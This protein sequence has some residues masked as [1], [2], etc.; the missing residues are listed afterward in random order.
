MFNQFGQEIVADQN[1]YGTYNNTLR[2]RNTNTTR[3][4]FSIIPFIR[5]NPGKNKAKNT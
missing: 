4:T 3:P 5:S 2:R 1:N